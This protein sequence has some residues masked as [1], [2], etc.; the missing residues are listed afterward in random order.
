MIERY[1]H[2]RWIALYAGFGLAAMFWLSLGCASI[3]LTDLDMTALP[4]N[5]AMAYGQIKVFI[6][7]KAAH[8]ST[9]AQAALINSQFT[10]N[11]GRFFIHLVNESSEAK[12]DQEIHNDGSF[13]WH[14]PAGNY[15]VAGFEWR[16]EG[17]YFMTKMHGPIRARVEIPSR[18]SACYL[19]S[20]RIEFQDAGRGPY[21]ISVI[22]ELDEASSTMTQRFTRLKIDSQRCIFKGE[23]LS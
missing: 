16:R 9:S 19:G 8:W 22:D 12:Y 2:D 3:D 17:G 23:T 1:G 11:D 21:R 5:E 4:D 10:M 15:F 13:Y 6:G 7:E 18:S 20:L 14:L